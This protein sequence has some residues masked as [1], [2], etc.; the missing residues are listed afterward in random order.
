MDGVE[1]IGNR[2]IRAPPPP[3]MR[4]YAH[5]IEVRIAELWTPVLLITAEVASA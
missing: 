1:V 3:L 5:P 4:K 2:K